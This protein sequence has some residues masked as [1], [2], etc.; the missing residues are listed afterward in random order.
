MNG[1]L[2]IYKNS[3][4]LLL[5]GFADL[6][7][8]RCNLD[9]EEI[10][11]DEDYNIFNAPDPRYKKLDYFIFKDEKIITDEVAK[12]YYHV[13]SA[14]FEEKSY[15]FNHPDLKILL[16]LSTNPNDLR[17]PYKINSSYYIEANIDNNTKFQ[18]IKNTSDKI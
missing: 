16:C 5:E 2:T 17:S 4:T 6:E 15:R 11:T 13:V 9:D 7:V 8:S 18:K 1:I 3:H 12:M 10:E 14:L